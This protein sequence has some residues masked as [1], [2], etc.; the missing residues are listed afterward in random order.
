MYQHQL[1]RLERKYKLLVEKKNSITDENIAE[2]RDLI[3]SFFQDSWHLR[4]WLVNSKKVDKNSLDAFLSD[5][6]ELQ[7][8]REI[9]NTSK[10]LIL[11]RHIPKNDA[12][13]ANFQ[14]IDVPIALAREY[15][16]EGDKLNFLIRH[17]KGKY[18]T[19]D[20]AKNCL[21]Q[22]KNFIDTEL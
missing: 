11:D 8:C 18:D 14:N 19:F 20:L 4:D 21:V 7:I 15:N 16:P 13:L 17:K 6:L 2:L 3:L 12:R 22:W 10:H 1:E 5:S 9:C